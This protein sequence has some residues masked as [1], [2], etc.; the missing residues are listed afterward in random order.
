MLSIETGQ[1]EES[2]L[3]DEHKLMVETPNACQIFPAC[4]SVKTVGSTA[5]KVYNF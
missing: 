5:G 1:V 2:S 3:K 4:K